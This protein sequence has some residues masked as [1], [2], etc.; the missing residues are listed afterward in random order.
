MVF[1]EKFII[2]IF[3]SS[4]KLI[5]L[6]TLARFLGRRYIKHARS[7]IRKTELSMLLF[8]VNLLVYDIIPGVTHSLPVLFWL[9]FDPFA[10]SFRYIL[11]F[12]YETGCSI[13]AISVGI[14]NN[15]YMYVVLICMNFNYELLG[16]RAERVGYRDAPQNRSQPTSSLKINVYNDIVELIRLQLKMNE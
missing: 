11:T 5:K 4:K 6:V 13:A 12:A 16:E 3:L 7:H 1:L 8:V 15:M 10:T 9:P 14:S 2:V